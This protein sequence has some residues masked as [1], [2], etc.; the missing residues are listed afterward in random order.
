[1]EE[2]EE[3]EPGRLDI[4]TRKSRAWKR[5]AE[6][7]RRLTSTLVG[8]RAPGRLTPHNQPVTVGP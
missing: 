7:Q 3:G 2:G 8:S 4:P 5:L 1:M 6:R